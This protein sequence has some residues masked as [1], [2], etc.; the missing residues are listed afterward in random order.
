[1]HIF[2]FISGLAHTCRTEHCVLMCQYSKAQKRDHFG[3][4]YRVLG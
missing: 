1:M 4:R 2:Q 3:E